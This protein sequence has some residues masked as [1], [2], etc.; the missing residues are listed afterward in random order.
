[1]Q[2]PIFSSDFRSLCHTRSSCFNKR[3]LHSTVNTQGQSRV[4]VLVSTGGRVWM[5][6]L[7]ECPVCLQN[8][9][10][11]NAI[12]RVLSCGHTVCEACLVQLHQQFPNTIRCPACTQLVK[13]SLKQT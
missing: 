7:P 11:E 8:Y 2:I 1:M 13:Y 4:T 10:D 3:A 6:E 9:D 5:E 12:P